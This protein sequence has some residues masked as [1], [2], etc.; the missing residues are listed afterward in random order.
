MKLSRHLPLPE[1]PRPKLGADV[2][3][4]RKDEQD[5][6]IEFN[7]GRDISEKDREAMIEEMNTCR[8]TNWENFGCRAMNLAL[9]FPDRREELGLD[10]KAFDGMR[11]RMDWNR[12]TRNWRGLGW[13][14]MN[15]A[16]LASETSVIDSHGDLRIVPKRP[17]TIGRKEVPLPPIRR[18][19]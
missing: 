6:G 1:C 2:L 17:K 10:E 14:A 11:K 18:V 15:L 5:D 16:V 19:A 9:L 8:D 12:R 7:P 4:E 13:S 3:L